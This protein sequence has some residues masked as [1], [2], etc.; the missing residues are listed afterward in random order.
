MYRINGVFENETLALVRIEGQ[1]SDRELADWEQSLQSI[2]PDGSRRLILDFCE[3]AFIS[4]RAV[5]ALVLQLG[6]E[7]L[8][9]NCSTTLRNMICSAGCCKNLL[10]GESGCRVPGFRR[11]SK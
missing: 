8:L 10:G 6:A 2:R 11:A 1:V 4:P 9:L 7:T 5:E 3:V